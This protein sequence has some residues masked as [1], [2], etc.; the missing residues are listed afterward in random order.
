MT[1]IEIKQILSRLHSGTR[2]NAPLS[3]EATVLWS[4]E[5]SDLSFDRA[6]EAAGDL[7]RKQTW[8]PS[9]AEFLQAYWG[10]QTVNMSVES[11]VAWLK[12]EEGQRAKAW[13]L[14]VEE[15]DELDYWQQVISQKREVG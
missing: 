2:S 11:A 6:W 9:I 15:M 4:E 1:G 10:T 5:L 13:Q 14:A 7:I 3:K 8:F 12:T